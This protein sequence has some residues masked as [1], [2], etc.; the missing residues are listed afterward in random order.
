[1]AEYTVGVLDDFVAQHFLTGGDFGSEGRLHSHHYRVEVTVTG[2]E[3]DG[4]GFLVDIV[5]LRD[6]LGRLVAR[7]RDRTLNDLPEL[8][9]SNPG[10]EVV[11]RSMT[12]S[13]AEAFRGRGLKAITVK[14][15]ENETAWA[16]HRVE[17]DASST[18]SNP[19]NERGRA[20]RD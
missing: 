6:E 20:P 19:S 18:A 4:H 1:M 17:L 3:L 9:G 12:R 2:D 13:L 16:S 11:A 5:R 15:W 14:L 10:V 8:A 7:Y